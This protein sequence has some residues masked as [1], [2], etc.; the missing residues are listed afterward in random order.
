[1]SAHIKA[2]PL[3]DRVVV[4]VDEAEGVSEGGLIIPEAAKERP[5]VGTVL[6]KGP[7]RIL[8][9]G[10]QTPVRVDVGAKVIFPKYAGHKFE[11][12]GEDLM[13]MAEDELLCVVS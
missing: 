3:G 2:A 7:G 1:M 10:S 13:V 5:L 6:A 9:C 8:D 11:L 12:D 4:R